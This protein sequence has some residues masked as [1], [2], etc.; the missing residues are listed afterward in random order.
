METALHVSP[1][2]GAKY[3]GASIG[4]LVMRGVAN[5]DGHDPLETHATELIRS[6]RS[7]LSGLDRNA[8][9]SL[10]TIAAYEAY[11][12]GFK[13]TYHVRL[14]LESVILK[15]KSLPPVGALVKAMFIVELKNQLLTA[16][17]DADVIRPAMTA[18][19]AE[20]SEQYTLLN[21]AEQVCKAGDM[22]ISDGAGVISSIVYGPDH[23]TRLTSTSTAACYTVY[24]VPGVEPQ[25]VHNH[26]C[27][28]RDLLVVVTPDAEVE[29]LTVHEAS[30]Q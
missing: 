11:Y 26:L 4:I 28:L 9:K 21:G 7:N 15:G 3:P 25:T 16:G 5:P 2:L 14:Q 17:H 27:D 23:R 10:P 24:G 22:K 13:K 20:G 29:E 1:S 8:L 6:L 18:A 30:S 12:R 19:A